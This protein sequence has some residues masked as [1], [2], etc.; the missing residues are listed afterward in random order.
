[1][2]I[3]RNV[4][5]LV[6]PILILVNLYRYI[7]YADTYTFKGFAYFHQYMSN[8][9]ALTYTLEML[10]KLS[11]LN[12]EVQ[13]IEVVDLP[14]FFQAFGMYFKM[15]GMGISVPFLVVADIVSDIIWVIKFFVV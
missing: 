1:M 14:T 13:S 3:L 9:N 12:S 6:F 8:F 11:V 10:D 15:I 2:K 4:V 5:L 7:G